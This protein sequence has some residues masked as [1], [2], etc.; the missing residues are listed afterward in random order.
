MDG[1]IGEYTEP[2]EAGPRVMLVFYP[3]AFPVRWN[4]CSVTADFFAE[5]FAT[6]ADCGLGDEAD[7]RDFVGSAGYV[8]NELIENAVKFSAGGTVEVDAGVESGEFVVVVSNQI[9][10]GVVDGLR[11]KFDE[12]ARSDPQELLLRR[13]EENAENPEMSTSGLGFLTMMSD[14]KAR[15]GWRFAPAPGNPD[16]ALLKTTARLQVKPHA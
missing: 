8:L 3:G 11:E 7:R 15:I 6:V 14:Y 4:Q 10:A 9:A 12:L 13:V 5:Y 16:N 2:S 1:I